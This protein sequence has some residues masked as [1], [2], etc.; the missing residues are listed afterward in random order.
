MI[1]LPN[2]EETASFNSPFATSMLDSLQKPE[3]AK[4]WSSLY[5]SASDVSL[6]LLTKLMQFN[7][8]KRMT[9]EQGLVHAYCA[10]FHD[11]KTETRASQPVVIEIDDN[12]K[13]TTSFYRDRLYETKLAKESGKKKSK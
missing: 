7:P 8:T 12:D 1:G 2:D 11:E 4:G 3:K 6:D 10:Q 9:A 13:K 5:P